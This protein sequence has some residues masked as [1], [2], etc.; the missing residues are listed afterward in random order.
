VIEKLG[1]LRDGGSKPVAGI[2]DAGGPKESHT[3]R[4]GVTA[5]SYSKTRVEEKGDTVD[6]EGIWQAVLAKIPTQK[7]FVRNSASAAYV[8]GVE[9]R[10]F[11]LG[12]APGDKAAMDILGT[13]ANRKFVETLLHEISGKDWTLKLTVSEELA[14]KSAAAQKDSPSHDFKDEPLIQD[15]IELFNAKVR[16]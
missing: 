7:G 9:G 13:Q 14:S 15:A 11:K 5:P 3:Q 12:F 1:E 2:G 10:N 16:S 8:L 4:A 6:S